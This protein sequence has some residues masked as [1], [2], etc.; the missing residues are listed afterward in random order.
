MSD[1]TDL[2]MFKDDLIFAESYTRAPTDQTFHSLSGTVESVFS[3]LTREVYSGKTNVGEGIRIHTLF[4]LRSTVV[5]NLF[6]ACS[7]LH[8]GE[9]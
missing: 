6:C 8:K 1:S 9:I 5:E 7:S 3:F 4:L 2:V